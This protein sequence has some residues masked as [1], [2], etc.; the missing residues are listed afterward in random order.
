MWMLYAQE[1]WT[2]ALDLKSAVELGALEFDADHEAI[3][4]M[5]KYYTVQQCKELRDKYKIGRKAES[6]ESL[7]NT[8]EAYPNIILIAVLVSI[9]ITIIVATIFTVV[10][11]RR[12]QNGCWYSNKESCTIHFL[13]A[14]LMM[15]LKS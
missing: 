1:H 3:Y 5:E 13:K 7:S 9:I 10:S 4:G 12:K 11:W 14:S 15:S 6:S 2:K 8:D